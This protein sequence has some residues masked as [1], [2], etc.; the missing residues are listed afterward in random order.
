MLLI[1]WWGVRWA[2]GHSTWWVVGSGCLV[3]GSGW[4]GSG[5]GAFSGSVTCIVLLVIASDPYLW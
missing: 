5:S 3:V 2:V 4:W 1:R